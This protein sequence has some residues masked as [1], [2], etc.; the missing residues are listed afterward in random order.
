[1]LGT[2]QGTPPFLNPYFSAQACVVSSKGT[3]MED[4]LPPRVASIISDIPLVAE[5]PPHEP[6]VNLSTPPVHKFTSP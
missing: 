1:M 2:C 4:Y 5:L 3:D 6:F